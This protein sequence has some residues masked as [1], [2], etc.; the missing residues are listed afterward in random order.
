[1]TPSSPV[2]CHATGFYPKRVMMFWRKDGEELHEGVDPG[3][4]LP[5]NDG[6]F[7]M[8]VDLNVS[9]FTLEDWS[10]FDCVFHLSDGE[11]VIITRLNETVIRTNRGG[12]NTNEEPSDMMITITAAVVVSVALVLVAAV[13]AAVYKKKKARDN[14]CDLSTRLNSEPS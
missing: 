9:S 6:T 10:R 3:E 2:S 11:D 8:S 5:N 1:M 14:A 4:I 7:Q 12:K 13:F